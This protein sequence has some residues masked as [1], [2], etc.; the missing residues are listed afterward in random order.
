MSGV[1]RSV[2]WVSLTD[3]CSSCVDLAALAQ[4]VYAQAGKR[5]LCTWSTLQLLH[6]RPSNLLYLV[7]QKWNKLYLEDLSII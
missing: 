4:R 3:I 6:L 2:N 1:E 5:T 7:K